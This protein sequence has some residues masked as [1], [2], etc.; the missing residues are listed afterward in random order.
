MVENT[1]ACKHRLSWTGLIT[2]VFLE[3]IEWVMACYI[4][5]MLVMPNSLVFNFI[6]SYGKFFIQLGMLYVKN[7]H[8]GFV[9]LIEFVKEVNAINILLRV[10]FENP[11][12][13]KKAQLQG[14]QRVGKQVVKPLG[15]NGSI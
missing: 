9:F 11:S 1:G 3:N 8:G 10:I 5:Y 7:N 14:Q 15:L 4:C 12:R 13:K 6:Q 2:F